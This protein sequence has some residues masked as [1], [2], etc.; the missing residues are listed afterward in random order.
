MPYRQALQAAGGIAVVDASESL[1]SMLPS[2]ERWG[3]AFQGIG[4]D[5]R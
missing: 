5:G 1:P 2:P 4:H 3:Q